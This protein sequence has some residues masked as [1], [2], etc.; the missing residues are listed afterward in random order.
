M[1]SDGL[2]GHRALASESESEAEEE[3]RPCHA[4]RV[5][6]DIQGEL[7][8]LVPEGCADS[9]A[10]EPTVLLVENAALSDVDGPIENASVRY[11]ELN[12]I[13]RSDSFGI[14]RFSAFAGAT[15]NLIVSAFGHDPDSAAVAVGPA[16]SP[17]RTSY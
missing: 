14:Y 1:G 2:G 6:V 7:R 13:L 11:V 17:S 3:E 4:V 12:N 9:A 16:E 5:G 10:P 8:P 15:N